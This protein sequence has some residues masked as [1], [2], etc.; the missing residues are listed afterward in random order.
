MWLSSQDLYIR[1]PAVRRT[2]E[3]LLDAADNHHL[4]QDLAE[5]DPHSRAYAADAEEAQAEYEA[6]EA[7]YESALDRAFGYYTRKPEAGQAEA[8][9]EA[10]AEI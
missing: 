4:Q 1:S 8:R 7:A 2:K 5:Y 10:E 9:P 6:A 3:A